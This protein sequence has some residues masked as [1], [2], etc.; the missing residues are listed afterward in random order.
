[1]VDLKEKTQRKTKRPRRKKTMETVTVDNTNSQ[2]GYRKT[3][4]GKE[5]T[6][7]RIFI[8]NWYNMEGDSVL[9]IREQV[10]WQLRELESLNAFSLENKEKLWEV[11]T[12]NSEKYKDLH[13]HFNK[14]DKDTMDRALRDLLMAFDLW[15]AWTLWKTT[16]Y[17]G[18]KPSVH[19]VPLYRILIQ[20]MNNIFYEFHD[21]YLNTK[22]SAIDVQPYA[23]RNVA[24]RMGYY[25]LY[26]FFEYL[27][28][29]QSTDEHMVRRDYDTFMRLYKDWKAN[30]PG[31]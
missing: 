23:L 12:S 2:D 13:D 31:P 20:Y 29:P 30:L 16:S 6:I 11:V 28:F 4:D 7:L 21:L 14:F 26:S 27:L 24:Q 17:T 8:P 3:S 19:D 15:K 18:E 9:S 10:L 1:V 22:E 5:S 25:A